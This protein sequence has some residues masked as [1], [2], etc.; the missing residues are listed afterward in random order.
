MTRP[1]SR[2][3]PAEAKDTSRRGTGWVARWRARH[4]STFDRVLLAVA[5]LTWLATVTCQVSSADL[6]DPRP[7]V[8]ATVALLTVSAW[9]LAAAAAGYRRAVIAL[10]SAAALGLLAE[11]LG[12]RTGLPFGAYSYT[13]RLR[14]E[15][16]GVPA[17]VPLAWFA[18]GLP[19]Y[20][21]AAAV[22]P[23]GVGR[24]TARVAERAVLGGVA[25]TAWDLFL[26]PQ[27]VTLGYWSWPGGGNYRG[28]PLSNYGG[29][30]LVSVLLM[31][32][33]EAVLAGPGSDSAAA[34]GLVGLYTSMTVVETVGFLGP[35]QLD[36]KVAATG[37]L[38]MGAICVAAWTAL[39]RRGV[40]RG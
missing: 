31:L 18:M 16:A 40:S 13:G 14:P 24:R 3:L 10:V 21:A 37:G 22:F 32:V 28:I 39:R 5:A 38:T 11:W 33:L 27:M 20:A 7:L 1:S 30:L 2:H 23:D 36:P 4:T 29:W 19:A 35:L 8:L 6:A 9:C 34:R 17:I 15:L 12:T 25:L 26:D